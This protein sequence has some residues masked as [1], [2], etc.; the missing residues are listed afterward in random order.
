M[1]HLLV[2]ISSRFHHQGT[3]PWLFALLLLIGNCACM[4]NHPAA[5]LWA[6]CEHELLPSRGGRH[7]ALAG[8]TPGTEGLPVP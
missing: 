1:F 4:V 5:H 8:S 6:A 7:P 2:T 3:A